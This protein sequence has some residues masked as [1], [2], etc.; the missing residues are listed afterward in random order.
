MFRVQLRC[1]AAVPKLYQ[2]TKPLVSQQF[3]HGTPRPTEIPN[4]SIYPVI[5]FKQLNN[6]CLTFITNSVITFYNLEFQVSLKNLKYPTV[7]SLGIG[8]VMSKSFLS[9]LTQLCICVAIRILT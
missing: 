6:Y 5:G 3:F 7:H 9:V 1:N 2:F 4:A 8:D